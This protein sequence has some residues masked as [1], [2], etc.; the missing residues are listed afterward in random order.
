MGNPLDGLF[1]GLRRMLL[2]GVE[3]PFQP[4]L[5]IIAPGATLT[6]GDDG[7]G[8]P[9][10]ELDLSSLAGGGSVSPGG[11][12]VAVTKATA[13]AGVATTYARSDHKHDITTAA[14]SALSLSGVA[15]A[16]GAS[17]SLARADHTHSITGR[18][19]A[20]NLP[21]IATD[22]LLGRDTAGSGDLETIGLGASLAMSGAGALQRAALT[23]DVTAAAD[24]NTTAIASNVIV[25]ADINTAAA[26]AH[27]KLAT[28]TTDSLLGRDTAGTGALETITLNA[29]LAMTGA[30]AL[31]RAALTGDVTAT[32]GSNATAI[33]ANVIVDADIN[34]AAAIA[35]SKLATI[36]TDSLLG[37]DTAGTG[38]LETITLDSNTLSMNGTRVLQRAALTG[39]VTCSAGSGVTS[40]AAGVITNTHVNAA[41]AI[42]GTKIA[43]DFGAQTVRSTGTFYVGAGG[44][45]GFPST[46]SMRIGSDWTLVGTDAS[47]IDEYV[48]DHNQS[49][50]RLT[51][52][53]AGT[54]SI[55]GSNFY[56]VNLSGDTL[57]SARKISGSRRVLGLFGDVTSV[58]MNVNTGD[59]VG[60]M[61]PCATAPTAPPTS[62]TSFYANAA[63]EFQTIGPESSLPMRLGSGIGPVYL[64]AGGGVDYFVY[65]RFDSNIYPIRFGQNEI[66]FQN[67]YAV[68]V[69]TGTQTNALKSA[70]STF[71]TFGHF[72]A[73]PQLGFFGAS[74]PKAADPG[75][76]TAAS[77]TADGTIA[78][79][80]ASFNQTTLNN[81]FKDLATKYNLLRDL[82][83][84]YGLAA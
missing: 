58:E 47:G 13:A 25:D 42:A 6:E 60:H 80:G 62:G 52:G 53:R 32:A 4:A 22:S 55:K 18:V 24:S 5:N 51:I 28:I 45:G 21:Q 31:Q 67:G 63:G 9:T 15:A 40:I 74:V 10:L 71:F 70:G 83:R 38:A 73:T 50:G 81:N 33:A 20:A 14:P 79:V 56:T 77:G 23:G 8:N 54:T 76:L 64:R 19:A 43:P 82:L 12:P 65:M 48:I 27:S 41:A 7:N 35:H 59:R 29:T 44:T 36:T 11:A 49:T 84:N 3:K 26:I 57:L 69:G 1:G 17:A 72:D 39:E 16:E 66:Q 30:G 78:D 37:R 46:G 34:T 75:A 68:G 2:G 61:W